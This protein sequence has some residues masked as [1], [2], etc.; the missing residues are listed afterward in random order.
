ME[1]HVRRKHGYLYYTA[2]CLVLLA[3]FL[4][5]S[6][7]LF[8][9]VRGVRPLLLVSLVCAISVFNGVGAS[10]AFGAIAGA[11][12]DLTS[13][14]PAGLHTLTMALL[15]LIL[16]LLVEYRFNQRLITAGLLSLGGCFLYYLALFLL[17]ELPKG[18]EGVGA[19][20][21]RVSLLGAFYTWLFV[22]PFYFAARYLAMISQRDR[23][24]KGPGGSWK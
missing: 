11:L 15:A 19:Y 14:A 12:I 2:W 10:F 23:G 17:L 6:A 16:S 21:G 1:Y 9:A 13:G 5:Q 3:T 18:Y 24:H 8:P 22:L 4:V 7:S 20:F